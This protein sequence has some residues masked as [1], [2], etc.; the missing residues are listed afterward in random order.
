MLTVVQPDAEDVLPRTGNRGEQAHVLQRQSG[1][2]RP[3]LCGLLKH[4]LQKRKECHVAVDEG[5]HI[6]RQSR[7][8]GCTEPLD[9]KD[10][11]VNQHA[12]ASAAYPQA[13]CH[14][15][16]VIPSSLFV[17]ETAA[18]RATGDT[19][20]VTRQLMASLSPNASSR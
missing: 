18:N 4:V 12:E 19:L 8:V 2:G 9:V 10:E 14:Q 6:G 17:S 15:T 5:Q 7:V 11:S 13:I 1:A 20:S 3:A 16:H